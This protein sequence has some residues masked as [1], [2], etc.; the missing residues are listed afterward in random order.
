M[1]VS[2]AR[3]AI[4]LGHKGLVQRQRSETDLRSTEVA[5]THAGSSQLQQAAPT[6][7]STIRSRLFQ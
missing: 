2:H 5:V 3:I 1:Q 6:Y 7:L 4:D